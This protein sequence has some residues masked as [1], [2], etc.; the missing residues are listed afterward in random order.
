MQ[1]LLQ[2]CLRH[3]LLVLAFV[4]AVCV[5]GVHSALKLPIDA[6]PDITSTQVQVLTQAPALG[7]VDVERNV[8]FP[9]ESAMSGLPG[10]V[11]LRSIS[12]FGLSSV[13]IVFDDDVD[14]WRARQ[15]VSERLSQAR[16]HLPPTAAPEL[17]PQATGLGEI[18]LFEV[19]G[20]DYTAMELRDVLDWF[21]A[22]ELRS[23][24]GVVEVNSW[25]GELKTYEVEVMPER[26][27][28]LNVSLGELYTAL[29][30]N[31]AAAG[32]GYLVRSGEQL[33]VRG[34]GRLRTLEEIADV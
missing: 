22:F 15:L 27:R 11:S 20:Q 23:V 2:F 32:G 7:P 9:I 5:A 21:I 17:G 30:R 1:T 18:L 25:G 6:V 19:K 10:L 33:V 3:R 29:E 8:T 26:M 12:R 34:E 31:N 4:I 24:P 16:E 13:T 28:A 14:P